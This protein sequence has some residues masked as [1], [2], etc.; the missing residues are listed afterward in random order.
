[1][2]RTGSIIRVSNFIILIFVSRVLFY[3]PTIN[4]RA[5]KRAMKKEKKILIYEDEIHDEFSGITRNKIAIDEH[6]RY[7]NNNIFYRF[8]AFIVYRLIMTPVAYIYLKLKFNYK[9]KNKSVLKK[10][11]K[12]PY[13][14]Y[15]NHTQVPG[16]GYIPNMITFPQKSY[17]IVSPENLAL[18]GTRTFM[19][20]I[21]AYPLPSDFHATKNFINGIETRLKQKSVITIYPE[22]H[23]WPYYT[24]IRPFDYRSFS[25]PISFN[26][27]TFAFTVTYQK[28][29]WRKTPRITIYLDGPFYPTPNV[30]KKDAA[31]ILHDGVIDAMR[32]RSENSNYEYITYQKKEIIHD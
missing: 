11:K 12:Q 6:F 26:I 15:G 18:K 17:V 28:R 21:G 16:D 22:A 10:I 29:H 3:K 27:P 2:K 8:F 14:L 25:Y 30:N 23:I 9:I 13:F 24:K 1:M 5:R 4:I 32:K 19:K 31:I 20:M 7:I